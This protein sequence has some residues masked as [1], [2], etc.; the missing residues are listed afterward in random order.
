MKFT[1]FSIQL[2]IISFIFFIIGIVTNLCGCSQKYGGGCNYYN[3]KNA[4]VIFSSCEK[5]MQTDDYNGDT[6]TVKQFDDDTFGTVTYDCYVKVKYD[7]GECKIHRSDE[8]KCLQLQSSSEVKHCLN[9]INK[10]YPLNSTT[11]VYIK[12]DICY[13]H[14]YVERIALCGMVFL[15]FWGFTFVILL[16]E[17]VSH[18]YNNFI[19]NFTNAKYS[20]F[21]DED[22]I[23][24][25]NIIPSAPIN[26]DYELPTITV[27]ASPMHNVNQFAPVHF[28]P[29]QVIYLNDNDLERNVQEQTDLY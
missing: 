21:I 24:E 8:E 20:N 15:I 28:V 12:N 9:G 29:N 7:Y 17:I 16:F 25:K 6:H 11:T 5:Y 10:S 22:E 27:I 3:I 1:K 4:K 14:H 13:S 19:C 2:L 18:N 26:P 23:H